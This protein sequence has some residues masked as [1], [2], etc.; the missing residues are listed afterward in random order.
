MRSRAA[1]DEV[2]DQRGDHD[3]S[4]LKTS[5][6]M[7]EAARRQ[8]EVMG[9]RGNRSRSHTKTDRRGRAPDCQWLKKNHTCM[10]ARMRMHG[11]FVFVFADEGMVSSSSPVRERRESEGTGRHHVAIII[12]SE[13]EGE[14]APSPSSHVER[15][16]EGEGKG[17]VTTIR[18]ILAPFC[19]LL[20]RRCRSCVCQ[21]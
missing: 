2:M 8:G 6:R 5:V 20:C 21:K 17:V 12:S 16:G 11:T 19:A 1:Q 18:A 15:R 3:R 10:Q 13:G 9:E 7:G 14:S 4:R